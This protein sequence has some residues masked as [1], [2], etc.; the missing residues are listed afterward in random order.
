M[1]LARS[2]HVDTFTRDHLPPVDQW[3]PLLFNLPEVRYRERLNCAVELLD[4]TLAKYGADRRCLIDGTTGKIWKYGS[5][6]QH[7]NQIAHVLVEDLGLVPGNRVLLRSPNNPWLVACWIAV[8]KAGGVVVTTMPML[9]PLELRTIHEIARINLSIV[10]GRF[11]DDL[12]EADIGRLITTADLVGMALRKPADFDACDTAADDVALLAF[13]SGTTGRPKATMH[14]HR[15]VLANADTFSRHIVAPRKDDLFTG[16]P[17][18]GFT[19]GLGG[20]VVFPM[21]AG[22]ATLLLE[23]GTPEYMLPAIAQHRVTV[24]FT[25]PTAYRAL[26]A[27]MGE[28]DVSSLRRCVSAGEPLPL[29]TWESFHNATGVRIIDGIGS[30]EMLHVFISAADDDIRPG[31]TGRAVPGY[32]A[33]VIDDDGAAVPD[34]ELGH[35]AV[36][37]PTGCRYLDDERQ[38]AYVRH[39]WNLT[40]DTYTRDKDGYF[41]YQ[42]RSDDMIISAG[43]NIA[44][45]EVEAAL[46]RH[47]DVVEVAV[48]GVPDPERTMSVKAF[49]V[50]RSG[51]ARSEAT[52]EAL[53]EHSKRVIAPY[54]MPRLIEFIDALPRTSTGKVQRY[55]LRQAGM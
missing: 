30:T 7:A 29:A 41:W 48:V 16:S 54:K 40:G 33:A 43:Y 21:R 14:F 13:T 8:L 28:H 45:P 46:L 25:A 18:I 36:R 24:L 51:V 4:V 55:V 32:E 50:L 17:P 52:A 35:L 31:A 27:G 10:D 9:R 15:D 53:R 5:L 38:T 2:A 37:G 26:L 34:G 1:Q 47:P 23:K 49:V 20:L 11:V 12:A 22:A 19:F 44:G 39:G 6:W 42:A 3:P